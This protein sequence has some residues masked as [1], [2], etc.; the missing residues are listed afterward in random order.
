VTAGPHS[1][2]EDAAGPRASG[3]TRSRAD[4]IR[5]LLRY[6]GVNLASLA[7]DYAVFLSMMAALDLPVIASTVAYAVAF[8]LNYRLSRLFVFGS[9]GAHKGERR[10]FTEF[11]ATGLLGIVL[12]A[13]VTA[14]GVYLLDLAP[15]VAKTLAVLVSFVVLYLVRSRLVFTPLA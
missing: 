10:L 14:A 15:I 9:D 5:R 1:D 6:T 3:G 8:T 12:T 4:R 11:M 13:T 7:L 2:A